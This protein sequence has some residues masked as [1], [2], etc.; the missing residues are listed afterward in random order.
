MYI[1]WLFRCNP[2]LENML[3]ESHCQERCSCFYWDYDT[4]TTT[5]LEMGECRLN[6]ISTT[7][8]TPTTTAHRG[9]GGGRT[10]VLAITLPLL[11]LL[12]ILLLVGF[13]L[14][15]K[16]G[17]HQLSY[18]NKLRRILSFMTTSSIRKIDESHPQRKL[19]LNPNR[20]STPVCSTC[21]LVTCYPCRD[22]LRGEQHS[23]YNKS[24]SSVKTTTQGNTLDEQTRK[25][26]TEKPS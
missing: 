4:N 5:L 21:L 18:L 25:G 2:S 10:M 8:N 1:I 12:L 26:K 19:G 7:T 14:W 13:L 16:G 22:H 24:K 11:G 9:G 3:H 20:G 17:I 6:L 15:R 23:L